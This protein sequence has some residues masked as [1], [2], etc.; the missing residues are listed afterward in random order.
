[1]KTVKIQSGLFKERP[2]YTDQEIELTC[3]GELRTVKLFPSSPQPIRI[4]RFVE[5]RFG[6]T[7]VYEDLPEGLLGFTEFGPKGVVAIAVSRL[8]AEEGS[9]TAERRIST[10]L[11]HE[12]GHGLLHAHLF[13]LGKRAQTVSLFG[14]SIDRKQMK[15]LCRTEGIQGVRETDGNTGYEGRWWEYHANRVIG[16][17]LLPQS[18]VYEALGSILTQ[19]GVLGTMVLDSTRHARAV[20]TLVDTFDVNPVVARIRLDGMFPVSAEQ[21]LTL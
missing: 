4:D 6:I 9:K 11:A 16:A 20:Q 2:Y 17:L 12:A 15:L 18:L 3:A 1:M 13:V 10:T 7:P 8:L 5:K 14:D 19:R 21:Q